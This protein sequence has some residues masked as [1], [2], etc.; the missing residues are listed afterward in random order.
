MAINKVNY[1]GQTLIDTSED[2]AEAE[3]VLAGKT[4]HS[5][6]GSQSTG[7]LVLPEYAAII[8]GAIVSYAG[9]TAPVGWLM[10]DGSAVSRTT[11]SKLFNAIG[12]TYGTGDGSTTFN[13]PDL[14]GRFPVGAGV[15]YNVG[16]TGGSENSIIPYHNHHVEAISSGAQQVTLTGSAK[17]LGWSTATASGIISITSPTND[18]TASS[19]KNFG[20]RYYNIN[21]SHAHTVSAHDTNYAGTSGEEVGA[22]MPPYVGVNYIISTGEPSE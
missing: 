13:I 11:Y 15:N 6:S 18:R 2:T 21:A 14:R 7:T 1:G 5:K 20:H 9:N 10:C 3:D 4:F 19:G 22:N 8:A 17:A 16:S 12:T